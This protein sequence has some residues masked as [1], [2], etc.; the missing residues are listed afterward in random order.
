LDEGLDSNLY[1]TESKLI[2]PRALSKR[3]TKIFLNGE[4][5]MVSKDN[6]SSYSKISSLNYICG[7]INMEEYLKP[8]LDDLEYDDAIKEDKRSFCQFVGERLKEKQIIMNTFYYK[9]NIRPITIKIILLLLNIDLYFIFNGLFYNE[10]YLSE[11]FHSNEEETFFSFIPRSI[12]RFIYTTLVGFI[13]GIIIDCIFIEERRVKRIF[14]R[15]RDKPV[16]IRYEISIIITSIKNRYYIF[17]FLCLLIS[18]FSWYYAICF[19]TVYPGIKMEWIKSSITIII[20]MQILSI[21]LVLLESV[22]R[23]LSFYYKSEK[24]YKFKKLLS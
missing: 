18:I 1:K 3:S 23:S 12:S 16:E 20:I 24:L 9:E 11:L 4:K 17:I 2:I 6:N 10:K 22:L 19:N 5:A 21:I 15:E 7:N 14:L 13:I 8:D